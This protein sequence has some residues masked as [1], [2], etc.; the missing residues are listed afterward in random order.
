[1]VLQFVETLT[2]ARSPTYPQVEEIPAGSLV[3]FRCMVQNMYNPEWYVG[4]YTASNPET[5]ER[6]Q[7]TAQYRESLDLPAGFTANMDAAASSALERVPLHC[8]SIPHESSWVNGAAL[9]AQ[10]RLQVERAGKRRAEE[11]DM[12]DDAPASS[13]SMADSAPAAGMQCETDESKRSRGHGSDAPSASGAPGDVTTGRPP[14]V[15]GATPKHAAIVKVYGNAAA[16]TDACKVNETIEVVGILTLDPA[17][18]T[19]GIEQLSQPASMDP[20]DAGAGDSLLD[21]PPPPSSV[22]PRIHAIT[23]RRLSPAWNPG[24][25]NG[26]SA[27]RDARSAHAAAATPAAR[28]R[29]LAR[30]AATPFLGGDALAAEFVLLNALSRVLHRSDGAPIGA[31]AVAISTDAKAAVPATSLVSELKRLLPAVAH[32]PLSPKALGAKPFV[33]KKDYDTETLHSAALQLAPSTQVTKPCRVSSS[34]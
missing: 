31:F 11:D 21:A 29:I 20:K 28:A 33:P 10:Q 30:L 24:L 1:M 22:L 3:R 16:G 26:P 34:V 25:D 23:L 15:H 5:G 27:A 8:M 9:P 14:L 18:A 32:L 19:F 12:M 7:G 2:C 6:R 13:S 4:D 17:A